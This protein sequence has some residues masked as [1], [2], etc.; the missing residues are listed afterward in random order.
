MADYFVPSYTPTLAAL[1]DPPTQDAVS[2][3]MTAIIEPHAPNCAPLP[4]TAA[5]LDKIMDRVP[6]QWLT[7]L[8]NTTGATVIDQLRDSSIVHFAC[9]GIQDSQNPLNSGLMLSDGRL[10]VSLIMQRPE[11]FSTSQMKNSMSL[12][13]LSACETAK[14]DEKT[15]DEAMHLAASLLFAGFRGVVA[16][17]W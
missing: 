17:I 9:H 8:F 14:G 6:A 10:K 3:K 2:F 15:P 4:G 5:E 7:A 13:F 1:L 16:T 12:A 11:K